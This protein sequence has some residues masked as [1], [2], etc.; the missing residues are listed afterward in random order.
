[1]PLTLVL[2]GSM[3]DIKEYFLFNFGKYDD[4]N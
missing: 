1:M 2:Q 3:K 4:I